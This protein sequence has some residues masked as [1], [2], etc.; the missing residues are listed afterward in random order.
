MLEGA[1]PWRRRMAA[2][3]GWAC[4]EGAQ[5]LIARLLVAAFTQVS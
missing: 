5:R 1:Q 3:A 2:A 4:S